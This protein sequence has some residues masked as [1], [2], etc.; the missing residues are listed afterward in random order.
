MIKPFNSFHHCFKGCLRRF[1][2]FG[3]GCRT[4]L[5][6][7][8]VGSFLPVSSSLLPAIISI[9]CIILILPPREFLVAVVPETILI[10]LRATILI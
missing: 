10:P 4:G 7:A 9:P 3:I 2:P 8:S 1:S 5:L 6:G